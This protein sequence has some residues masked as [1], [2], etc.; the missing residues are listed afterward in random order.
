LL[1]Q[2]LFEQFLRGRD[3]TITK[4]P[5]V[6]CPKCSYHQQRGEAVK[7]ISEGKGFLFCGECGERITL[8]KAGE[9]VAL[10][11]DDRERLSRER[12]QTRRRTAFE[13][14]LVRVK[15][16]VRDEKK[17]APSCFLSYA[18]GDVGQERWM[19]GL[20]RDLE[21]AGVQ[22]IL[23]QK[24]NPQIGANVAR[25]IS[26]IAQSD[27]VAVVGT[28]QYLL[29]Y[30]NKVSTT[31]S[32]VAAEVD[33]INQ[34]LLGTEEMKATV[35]PLLLEGEDRSSLPPL[36]RGK[37]YAD[38][39]QEAVYFPMLF[40]LILTLYRIPFGHPAIEDI[41]HSLR[42]GGRPGQ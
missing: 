31:G 37:V 14:A 15:A 1:F 21:N 36:M 41:R 30:D 13:S 28:P 18:W 40:D 39:R 9:E 32:V 10:S 35:L 22:I 11:S 25:F 16:V 12:E 2:G 33:L 4:F 3:V 29:K 5:P 17:T 42:G 27:L 26:R 34:R 6:R 8:P 20:S 19:R 38:F 24:D 23:D 7:R